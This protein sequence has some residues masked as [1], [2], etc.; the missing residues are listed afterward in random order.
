MKLVLHSP[1][2]QTAIVLERQV[3]RVPSVLKITRHKSPN[4]PENYTSQESQLS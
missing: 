1:L 4:C 3:T 2:H